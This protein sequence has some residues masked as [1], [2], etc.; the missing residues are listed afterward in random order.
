MTIF[1][2]GNGWIRIRGTR[3][4]ALVGGIT[5]AAFMTFGPAVGSASAETVAEFLAGR[6]SNYIANPQ[7]GDNAASHCAW[8]DLT[9]ID[10][11]GVNLSRADLS[12]ANLASAP[13]V[14]ANLVRAYLAATNLTGANL[15]GAILEGSALMPAD[16]TVHVKDAGWSHDGA[17]V[18]WETPRMPIGVRF[19]CDHPSGTKFPLT[20][21]S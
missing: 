12:Y 9:G 14:G 15:T 16:I 19:G 4:A 17:Y 11:S 21:R 7:S 8:A 1:D 5:L 20:A 10:L 2:S 6:C 3:L 13:L 18:T